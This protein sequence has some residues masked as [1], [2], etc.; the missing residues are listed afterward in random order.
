MADLPEDRLEPSPPFTFSAVDYFGPFLVKEGRKEMK[1]WGVLFTC[2][3]SRAI[4]IETANSLDTD[5]FLNAYHRFVCRRGPVRKLRSDRGSNFIGGKNEL[6]A[7]LDEMKHTKI[8][9]ELLKEN[10]DW[11]AFE[12]NVPHA[13]HMG[14]VWERKIG[15][16]RKVITAL[17]VQYGD[18]LDDELLR[19]LLTE[20]EL[21]VNSRPLTFLD[22]ESPESMQPLTPNQLLTLKS[23]H[24]APW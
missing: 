15:C 8:S 23:S 20:V 16:A 24:A 2:M 21:I 11:V 12:M 5:S 17:L 4:H 9:P 6:D 22:T 7:A 10:C 18:Q 13:S 19:T 1:R 3:A 14:G